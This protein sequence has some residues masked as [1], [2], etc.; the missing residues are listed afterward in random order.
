M[1]FDFLKNLEHG[2]WANW[3][4]ASIV[5]LSGMYLLEV[6]MIKALFRWLG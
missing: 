2:D 4:A 6:G 5:P 1:K 3:L